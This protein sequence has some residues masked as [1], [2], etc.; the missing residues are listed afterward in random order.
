M[1]L[2]MDIRLASENAKFGF[3]FSRRG[4]VPEACSSYFLPRVVGISQA[5]EW[6]YSGRVFQAQEALAGGLVKEVLA[7]DA[8]L[9]GPGKSPGKLLRTP[10]P[11][12]SPSSAI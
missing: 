2:P 3:V 7:P 12:P 10:P 9:P 8:L 11:F 5:L 1:Q 6:A 4:I